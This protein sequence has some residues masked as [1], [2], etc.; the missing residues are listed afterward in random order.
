MK[1]FGFEGLTGLGGVGLTVFGCEHLTYGASRGRHISGFHDTEKV[2]ISSH[3]C[4]QEHDWWLCQ[5]FAPHEGL[6]CGASRGRRF[7]S[8]FF[9]FITLEP[10]V[11]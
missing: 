2:Q 7:P 6:T 1:A 10:R 9:F 8:L 11:E 3:Y 5:A 4:A